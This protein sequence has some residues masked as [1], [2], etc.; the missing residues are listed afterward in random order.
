MH[1]I[2]YI[3]IGIVAAV[4]I[5]AVLVMRRRKKKGGCGCGCGCDG[6]PHA[7]S[8]RTERTER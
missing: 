8:C 1:A 7:A 2:D 4:T 5:T 3:L 6:C